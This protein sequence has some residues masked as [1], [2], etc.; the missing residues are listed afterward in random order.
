MRKCPT[1]L[2]KLP[3]VGL[4]LVLFCLAFAP[5][6]AA[7]T[8][9][10]AQ[11]PDSGRENRLH[12]QADK[13]VS[14]RESNYI[15]FSGD[16][17]VETDDTRI[18]SAELK[19]YFSRLPSG[20]A[21]MSGEDVEKIVAS[22]NVRIDMDNRTATCEQAVYRTDTQILVLTGGLVKIKS[23]GNR[24]SGGRITFHRRTGEIIVDGADGQRVNAIIQQS[25]QGLLKPKTESGSP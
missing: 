16:V 18:R 8:A 20:G 3:R 6:G 5:R 1:F 7:A 25:E 15:H 13:L 9:P 23:E 24:I 22:G 10:E 4:L 12:V 19:V 17:D 14:L 11:G 2:S 21:G